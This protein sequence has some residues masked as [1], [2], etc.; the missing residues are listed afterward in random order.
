MFLDVSN[1]N[2]CLPF[3]TSS[4]RLVSCVTQFRNY[5]P[6]VSLAVS[7]VQTASLQTPFVNRLYILLL[8]GV[9]C[10]WFVDVF[11]FNRVWASNRCPRADYSP[12]SSDVKRTQIWPIR[13]Q[14]GVKKLQ[15]Y[16]ISILEKELVL[17]LFCYWS[18]IDQACM[19]QYCPQ[20]FRLQSPFKDLTCVQ[21]KCIT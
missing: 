4:F 2:Y 20:R 16:I 1:T 11:A 8:A 5:H 14:V 7:A 12:L 10:I 17:L 18:I 19:L 15:V 9:T 21:F 13:K 6:H 3:K